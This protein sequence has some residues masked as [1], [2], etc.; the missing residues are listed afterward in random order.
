MI[1]IIEIEVPPRSIKPAEIFDGTRGK[2][3]LC[4]PT[5]VLRLGKSSASIRRSP[6][7]K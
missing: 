5:R 2:G 6:G 1:A 7:G 3:K 4:S